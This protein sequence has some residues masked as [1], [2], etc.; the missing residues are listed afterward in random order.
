MINLFLLAALSLP[1][2][3]AGGC[4]G[5]LCRMGLMTALGAVPVYAR[6]GDTRKVAFY[7]HKGEKVTSLKSDVYVEEFGIAEVVKPFKSFTDGNRIFILSYRGEGE[8]GYLDK[9]KPSEDGLWFDDPLK[10]TLG[11]AEAP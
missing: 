8:F 5:E 3:E 1:Y 6:E 10:G 2:V 9:G 4:P 7:L 11:T